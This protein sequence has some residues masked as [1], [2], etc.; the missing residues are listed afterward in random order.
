MPKIRRTMMEEIVLLKLQP[1]TPQEPQTSAISRSISSFAR[2]LKQARVPTKTC[3]KKK[4]PPRKSSTSKELSS[5]V[6]PLCEIRTSLEGVYLHQSA[7]L[8]QGDPRFHEDRRNAQCTAIAAY[9]IAALILNN[10]EISRTFLDNIVRDGD[11]Y[12]VDCK[13]E[14]QVKEAFL[15][16]EE[17]LKIFH[18]NY[19]EVTIDIDQC[20]EGQFFSSGLITSLT[21]A[22]DYYVEI[23][24]YRD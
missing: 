13:K 22:I 4:E 14:N 3:S 18:V 10:G 20:G 5:T 11:K 8:H 6:K 12:Y 2:D 7:N 1:I 23:F 19:Q 24:I 16:P 9:S 17:L 21:A 15:Q